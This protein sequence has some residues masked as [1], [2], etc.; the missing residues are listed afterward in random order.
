MAIFNSYVKL[1]EGSYWSRL[2]ISWVINPIHCNSYKPCWL[3]VNVGYFLMNFTSFHGEFPW[4]S[5]WFSYGFSYFSWFP[6]RIPILH[7]EIPILHG[8]IPILHGE[9]PNSHGEILILHGEIPILHGEI[10]I[11]H[12]E[13]TILHGKITILHGEIPILH[14]E[15]PILHGN[16]SILHG[17][18]TML[19][20]EILILHGEIPILHGEIHSFH[21]EIPARNRWLKTRIKS[22]G[23]KQLLRATTAAR[24]WHLVRTPR[25]AFE[26]NFNGKWME[27]NGGLVW[28]WWDFMWFYWVL[29]VF[30][31]WWCYWDLTMR[32]CRLCWKHGVLTIKYMEV[33]LINDGWL[34]IFVGY[35]LVR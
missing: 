7:G 19:H 5:W 15:I 32:F 24:A 25:S 34:M 20:C 26:G 14:G 17:K 23:R 18:I 8:K 1:P 2:F 21:G 6:L 28:F 16:I 3:F 31:V 10:P 4:S 12:G 33:S 35:S 30:D 13:I 27:F 22:P 9:I 29:I 11:L